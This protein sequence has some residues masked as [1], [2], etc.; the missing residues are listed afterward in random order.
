MKITIVGRGN[1]GVALGDRLI[2]AGHG[3]SYAV[4]EPSAPDEIPV[5]ESASGADAVLLA[6][7]WSAVPEVAEE[8][9]PAEGTLL[10]DCTNP[11]ENLALAVGHDHSGGEEV[12]RRLPGASVFKAFN[13]VGFNIMQDPMLEGRRVMMPFCGDDDTKRETV[14]GLIEDVG[15]E[16]VD[17]G[18]LSNARLLEPM[19]MLWISLALKLGFG[20]DFGFGVM[21]R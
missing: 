1:V 13:T 21:R 7:P 19:A 14:R 2:G 16:A 12:Q 15:F 20:R 11:L 5:S 17:A 4:R 9:G 3:V 8:L 18:P 6:I 10:I